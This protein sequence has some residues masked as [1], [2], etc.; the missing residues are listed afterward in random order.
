MVKNILISLTALSISAFGFTLESEGIKN[1]YI[2][3]KYGKYGNQNLNGMP[4]LS[5]PLKWNNAPKSYA[6]V[7]EDLDAVPVIGFSWIHWIA[8]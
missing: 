3:Q 7:M 2:Q 1:S 4:S 8:V 5:I 6:L